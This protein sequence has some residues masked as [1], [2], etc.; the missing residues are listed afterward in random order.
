MTPVDVVRRLYISYA[1]GKFSKRQRICLSTNSPLHVN[2]GDLVDKEILC[3]LLNFPGKFSRQRLCIG[4][5]EN[6]R[7]TSPVRTKKF[8]AIMVLRW[9][10]TLPCSCTLTL[11]ENCNVFRDSATHPKAV[12]YIARSLM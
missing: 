5:D 12:Y 4:N 9:I 10:C 2:E 3:I 1:S 11:S 6:T 7:F 8:E